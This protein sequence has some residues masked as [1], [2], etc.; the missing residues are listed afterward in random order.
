M[1][2]KNNLSAF[3]IV[4]LSDFVKNL[5]HHNHAPDNWSWMIAFSILDPRSIEKRARERRR[6]AAAASVYFSI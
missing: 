3:G 4:E 5:T 6:I 1:H 2:K